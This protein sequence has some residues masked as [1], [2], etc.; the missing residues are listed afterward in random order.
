[1]RGKVGM[2]EMIL[3]NIKLDLYIWLSIVNKRTHDHHD[4]NITMIIMM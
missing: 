4:V 1:M 2:V 3:A